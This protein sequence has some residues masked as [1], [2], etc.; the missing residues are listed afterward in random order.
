MA[1]GS[2]HVVRLASFDWDVPHHPKPVMHRHNEGKLATDHV[3]VGFSYGWGSFNN[4]S[5]LISGVSIFC[6]GAGLSWYHGIMG[7]IHPSEITSLYWVRIHH[8]H[9]LHGLL[10][11]RMTTSEL[12][13]DIVCSECFRFRYVT[14]VNHC[15]RPKALIV[16]RS[17]SMR[18]RP[19]NGFKRTAEVFTTTNCSATLCR[20]I[21][22]ELQCQQSI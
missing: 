3:D 8:R 21:L 10:S 18:S 4:V 15:I 7:L 13:A 17:K 16:P 1:I 2:C 12:T 9:V 20:K 14:N 5:S 22:R 6:I 11:P 19:D